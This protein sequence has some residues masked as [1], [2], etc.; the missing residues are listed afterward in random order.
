MPKA[1][2]LNFTCPKDHFR[3]VFRVFQ[4]IFFIFVSQAYKI[5]C[6]KYLNEPFIFVSCDTIVKGKIPEPTFNWVGYSEKKEVKSYRCIHKHNDKVLNFVDKG[7]AI[8]GIHKAY[9]GL[10]GVKDYKDFY[11]KRGILERWDCLKKF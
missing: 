2:I 5:L 10:A 1:I 8:P 6:K 4:S 7:K 3:T 9:I 11:R